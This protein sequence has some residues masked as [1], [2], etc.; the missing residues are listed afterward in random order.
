MNHTENDNPGT[1]AEPHLPAMRT[2][3][4][5]TLLRD[6]D[7]E[8]MNRAVAIALGSRQLPVAAFNSSI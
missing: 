4:A 1:S 2:D 7:Q 8:Q 5:R 6:I 3:P